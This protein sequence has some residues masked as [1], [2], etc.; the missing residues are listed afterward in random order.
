MYTFM[1]RGALTTARGQ[2]ICATV[3]HLHP[4][5]EPHKK[6]LI[7]PLYSVRYTMKACV[8]GQVY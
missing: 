5:A 8:F 7:E 6:R 3:A 4:S 1:S 2:G